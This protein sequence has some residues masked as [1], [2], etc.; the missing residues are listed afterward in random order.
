MINYPRYHLVSQFALCALRNTCIFPATDVCPTSQN[1]EP[2][3]NNDCSL[4][5][6][7][8][9]WQPASPPG[10][11][12]PGLFCARITALISASTVY[13]TKFFSITYHIYIYL[14]NTFFQILSSNFFLFSQMH[15]TN[16]TPVITVQLAIVTDQPAFSTITPMVNVE[17]A[18]P[19]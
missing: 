2:I 5:P 1:T 16:A 18:L 6:Q 19:R 13:Y 3:R 15:T 17:I 9:I 8:S 14:S 7:R 10:S 12:P 4:R 11:H